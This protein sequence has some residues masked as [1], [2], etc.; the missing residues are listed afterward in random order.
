M[1][2]DSFGG[3]NMPLLSSILEFLKKEYFSKQN[4]ELDLR[5]FAKQTIEDGPKQ[6]N[7]HDCGLFLLKYADLYSCNKNPG[8]LCQED[9]PY[10]RKLTLYEIITNQLM[11]S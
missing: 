3:K 11:L 2:Y 9:M 6:N 7:S 1:Y 5:K 4:K 8:M 10:F